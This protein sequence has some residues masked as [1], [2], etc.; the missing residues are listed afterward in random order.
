LER[1]KINSPLSL[2]LP[3]GTHVVGRGGKGPESPGFVSQRQEITGLSV[4][5]DTVS[6][7][8]RLA[9]DTFFIHRAFPLEEFDHPKGQG[10]QV[11]SPPSEGA[12]PLKNIDH[13]I[14][15]VLQV[16]SPPSEGEGQG[17]GERQSFM[18]EMFSGPL[19]VMQNRHL[20]RWDR[21]HGGSR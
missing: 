6:E 5:E 2:T 9:P 11:P 17:E 10:L 12:S 14:G 18:H 16:P 1:I 19:S 4:R 20:P 8:F 21:V 7:P 15:Q 3:R 13:P